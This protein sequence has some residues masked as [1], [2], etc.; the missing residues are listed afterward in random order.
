[1][2]KALLVFLSLGPGGLGLLG[3]KKRRSRKDGQKRHGAPKEGEDGHQ[4]IGEG[5]GIG[6]PRGKGSLDSVCQT[7]AISGGLFPTGAVV[8]EFFPAC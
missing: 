3:E 4:R 2:G 5:K 8:F 6:A 7:K 1:M